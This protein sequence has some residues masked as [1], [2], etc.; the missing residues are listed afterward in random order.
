M[1]ACLYFAFLF[2]EEKLIQVGFDFVLTLFQYVFLLKTMLD[3]LRYIVIVLFLEIE[4]YFSF[5]TI[6]VQSLVFD[7]IAFYLFLSP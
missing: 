3:D 6:T 4:H 2:L 7:R 5:V 1:L